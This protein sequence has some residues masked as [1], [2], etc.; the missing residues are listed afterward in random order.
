[1]RV[2]EDYVSDGALVGYVGEVVALD[3]SV[4]AYPVEVLI[5]PY[6]L[7]IFFAEEELEAMHD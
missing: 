1:V 6:G 3:P 2:V 7:S 5:Q 4:T